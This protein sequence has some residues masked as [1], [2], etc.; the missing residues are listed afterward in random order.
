LN[1]YDF[2]GI[3]GILELLFIFRCSLWIF[4]CFQIFFDFSDIFRF[5][6]SLSS[7]PLFFF[8]GIDID[9]YLYFTNFIF[10]FVFIFI[11]SYPYINLCAYL[12]FNF[13]FNPKFKLNYP[14]GDA[15]L[16]LGCRCL[17]KLN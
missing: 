17:V 14:I 9:L 5:F 4:G 10:A 1:Y 13:K 12:Y 11:Y 15:G 8:I 7:L 6:L 16:N 3:A 2:G